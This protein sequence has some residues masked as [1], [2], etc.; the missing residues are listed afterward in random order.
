MIHRTPQIINTT[1]VCFNALENRT[2]GT[3]ALTITHMYILLW[4][5]PMQ[6]I[7][8]LQVVNKKRTH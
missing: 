3:N 5:L 4:K 2:R 7:I 6:T 1:S 8:E